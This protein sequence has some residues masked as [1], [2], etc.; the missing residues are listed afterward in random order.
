MA[1]EE[2]YENIIIFLG[3]C[4]SSTFIDELSKAGRIIVAS[5]AGDEP[6]Y[7]GPLDP[8]GVRDGEFFIT[9]LF[10]ELGRGENL[11]DGFLSAVERVEIHTDSGYGNSGPPYFDSAMQHPYLD[12]DGILP[13]S[14]ELVPG[15]DGDI[16]ETIVLGY[17]TDQ[18]DPVV[19][20]DV[21][22]FP[23]TLID[24]TEHSAL[25]WAKVSDLGN[26]DRVWVEIRDPGTTLE[27][28]TEQ[29]LVN[30]HELPLTINGDRYEATY[31]DFWIEGTYSLFFYAKDTEGL[32]SPFK[33]SYIYKDQLNSNTPPDQFSLSFPLNGATVPLSTILDWEDTQDSIDGHTL[34]YTVTISSNSDLANPDYWVY[35]E[36]GLD[37]SILSID[38]STGIVNQITYYWQVIAVDACGAA[39]ETDV[40][41]FTTDNVTNPAAGWIKGFVYN[42]DTE[43][44]VTTA[45]VQIEAL[46]LSTAGDGYYLGIIPPGS[47]DLSVSA[48]GFDTL[49][50]VQVTIPEGS[51]LT[52]NIGLSSSLVDSE[53]VA[54]IE[55]PSNPISILKGGTVNFLGAVSGGNSPMT[56]SWDFEGGAANSTLKSPGVVQFTT[57][58][59]YAVTFYVT[60]DD[61]DTDSDTVT[62]TVTPEDAC[63]DDPYKTAPGVCGCGVAD[64]DTDDDTIADCL[65]PDDDN[66]GVLD[67]DDHFPLDDTESLDTDADGTGDNAD[68]D[69]D[70]DGINDSIEAAGPNSGDANSD[71]IQ[72]SLQNNIA[73]LESYN[74]QGVVVLQTSDGERLSNCQA[75]GNPSPEDA[76][77]DIAFTYGF[78]D[79]TLSGLAVDG[80]TLLTMTLPEG[81]MPETYYKY[82]KTPDNQADHW[83]EFLYDGTT[84][85]EISGNVITLH[86]VDALR[87]DDDVALTNTVVDLGGPGFSAADV[88]L[89]PAA[90][91]TSPASDTT[92]TA[93]DAV[94]FE[95]D[96]SSGNPPFTYSWDFG[97]GAANVDTED[98]GSVT[99]ST[100]GTYTVTFTVTDVDGDS[101]S[102]SLTVTVNATSGDGGGGGGGCF[103]DSLQSK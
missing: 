43:E 40:W 56:F 1:Q 52:K 7:R 82:G 79:F 15:G 5:S 26:T 22:G 51:V 64:T 94:I 38:S 73:C 6:S 39:T 59:V 76:P 93:G 35:R 99:F 75:T 31:N 9:S 36:E 69:D 65:D 12:D 87:G 16:A 42:L 98:P 103:I 86:F 68:E 3:T 33:R 90:S 19:I 25:L 37:H 85:A 60:D 27:G 13:G 102:D 32:I 34:T 66:D 46:N 14:H 50:P 89:Q 28:G 2:I 29:Q 57:E 49:G 71:G 70:N 58:G 55:S 88:D 44:A 97:G 10:N 45:A 67:A 91:I 53:P 63:P 48:Q 101:S 74:G 92:V 84:G 95:G 47:Y 80:S 24:E 30:L 23:E 62:I 4:Y 11:R 21:I 61:G 54:V 78:F 81:E 18:V 41:S 100:A 8:T 77:A 20:T 96:V 83:Y 72:D 17:D